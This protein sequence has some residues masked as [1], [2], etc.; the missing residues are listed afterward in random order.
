MLLSRYFF[1]SLFYFASH[2]GNLPDD[3]E[4][5]F[6]KK[7]ELRGLL[8]VKVG[9]QMQAQAENKMIAMRKRRNNSRV[10]DILRSRHQERA[11]AE[12]L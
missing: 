1:S 8:M 6:E 10:S 11:I 7:K 12:A 2:K 4:L 5:F 3:L 9:S